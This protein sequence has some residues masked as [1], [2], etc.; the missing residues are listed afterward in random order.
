MSKIRAEYLY[1]HILKHIV[2]PYLG[3]S[4][5]FNDD[6]SRF[7]RR[8][9]KD[10]FVGVFPADRIPQLNSKNPYAIIN[11]DES[12]MPGSHWVGIMYMKKDK[13]MIYDSYAR[14]GVKILPHVKSIYKHI[15]D[16]EYDREQT[17]SEKNCGQR[18][19]AWLCLGEYFGKY[20]CKYI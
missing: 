18:C 15:V 10:K 14:R 7:C 6:L 3:M 20:L 12:G 11:L 9:L 4:T 2:E 13:V 16:T 5:T 17:I 1:N 19:V 8:L